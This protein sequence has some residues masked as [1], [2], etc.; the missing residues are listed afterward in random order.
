MILRL[1]RHET[2][3]LLRAR[4]V[5]LAAGLV[6]YALLAAPVLLARPPAHVVAA[7]A[8]WFRAADPELAL[9][10]FIWVDLALNKLAAVLG[11]ILA[12]GVVREDQ[13]R[14]LL[15]LLW[16]KPITRAQYYLA[17]VA[18]AALVLALFLGGAALVGLLVFPP[19][20]PAF[21]ALPFLVVSAVHLVGAL[22]AV[23]LSALVAALIPR[24]IVALLVS[25]VILMLLV[26]TAFI[27]FYN[28]DWAGYAELNPFYHAVWLLGHLGDLR[29]GLILRPVAILVTLH[30]VMLGLGVL[31]VRRIEA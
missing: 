20:I 30:A 26:G 28:P 14:G 6:A 23:T 21:R 19:Q 2:R 13:S 11:V 12:G 25:L 17:K 15:A 18:A 29:P 4:R 1:I 31:A 7:A 8:A 9:F 27:G 16:S 5:R 10:L 22:F 3:A 24:R